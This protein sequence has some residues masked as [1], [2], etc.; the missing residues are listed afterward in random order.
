MEESDFDRR[1]AILH[2]AVVTAREI[3][4]ESAIIAAFVDYYAHRLNVNAPAVDGGDN[5]AAID[6]WLRTVNVHENE[7]CNVSSGLIGNLT[8]SGLL[9]WQWIIGD[10]GR[11]C[12][13]SPLNQ[14]VP[15]LGINQIW[16]AA[17]KE[18]RGRHPLA[19]IVEAWVRNETGGPPDPAQY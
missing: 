8:N 7:A 1:L 15:L 6:A 16:R 13:R 14:D 18:E 10:E 3:D 9:F 5:A 17:S 4:D 2:E 11:L 19:P 12:A